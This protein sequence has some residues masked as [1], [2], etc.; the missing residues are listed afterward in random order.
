VF[1]IDNQ[2]YYGLPMFLTTIQHTIGAET[3]PILETWFL[4]PDAIEDMIKYADG[5]SALNAEFD[6]EGVVVRSYD[7][8]ISFKAISNKFLLNEK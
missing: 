8:S 1:D 3:V 6:R 5:K 7:R 2:S 4:L